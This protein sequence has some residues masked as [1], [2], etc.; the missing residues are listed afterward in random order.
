MI[1]AYLLQN[2]FLWKLLMVLINVLTTTS[3]Q[4]YLKQFF[5]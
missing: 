1:P 5:Y 4:G 3:Q 2:K